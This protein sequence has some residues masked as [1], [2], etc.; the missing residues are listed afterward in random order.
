[1]PAPIDPSMAISGAEWQISPV[2]GV[3]SSTSGTGSATGGGFGT[4]LGDALGQLT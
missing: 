2:E 4:L 1:M 3:D